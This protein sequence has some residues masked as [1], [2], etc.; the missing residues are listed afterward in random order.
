MRGAWVLALSLA[1][2][3]APQRP[4]TRV[5]APIL[6]TEKRATNT[7]GKKP[8]CPAGNCAAPVDQEWKPTDEE[9]DAKGRRVVPLNNPHGDFDF[10]I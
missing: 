3:A 1:C 8:T 10:G 5:A 7:R 4:P 9:W 6:K 2:T